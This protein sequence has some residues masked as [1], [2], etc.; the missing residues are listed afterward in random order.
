M[1]SSVNHRDLRRCSIPTSGSLI[2]FD[3][4]L[5]EK[6]L[7]SIDETRLYGIYNVAGWAIHWTQCK[8]LI[9]N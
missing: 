4:I 1:K 8:L 9:M 2:I 6:I 7:F 3:V 5:G